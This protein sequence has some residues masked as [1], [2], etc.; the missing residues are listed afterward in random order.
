MDIRLGTIKQASSN[1]SSNLQ[2]KAVIYETNGKAI[3]K[4]LPLIP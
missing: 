1:K 3:L 2:K 4:N